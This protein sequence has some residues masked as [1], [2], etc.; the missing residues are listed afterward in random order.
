MGDHMRYGDTNDALYKFQ[1]RDNSTHS[2]F[3]QREPVLHLN[4]TSGRNIEKLLTKLVWRQLE[5]QRRCSKDSQ[6][7]KE[8]QTQLGDVGN[9]KKL[10]T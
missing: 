7:I 2:G 1:F 9:K 5:M 4:S 10:Q 6:D 3:Q 8:V